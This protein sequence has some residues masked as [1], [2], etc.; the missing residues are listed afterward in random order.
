M[1]EVWAVLPQTENRGLQLFKARQKYVFEFA[2]VWDFFYQ[3]YTWKT[4]N[5]LTLLLFLIA[6]TYLSVCSSIL[7]FRNTFRLTHLYV[8]GQKHVEVESPKYNKW[9]DANREMNEYAGHY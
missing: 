7:F 8:G 6:W 5:T 2:K 3:S 1:W 4:M 9:D